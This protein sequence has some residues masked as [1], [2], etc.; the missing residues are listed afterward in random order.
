M[1]K[2]PWPRIA[3][4]VLLLATYV[5][6]TW[7]S[8]A[9]GSP[10][11]VVLH[12]VPPLVVAIAAETVTHLQNALTECVHHAHTT[13]T[14]QTQRAVTPAGADSPADQPANPTMGTPGERAAAPT[15]ERAG[16]PAGER[17]GGRSVNAGTRGAQRPTRSRGEPA[18]KPA[19]QARPGVHRRV[20][21]DHVAEAWAAWTPGVVVSPAW[22]RQVT[23][24]S[25]GLSPKVAAALNTQLSTTPTATVASEPEGRAA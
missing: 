12:S 23:D 15:G 17:P 25:R 6:N 24:C 11:G 2:P 18:R 13:A 3:K 1:H 7:T 20:L 19:A 8:W 21:A 16:T 14:H 22:V 4:W 9:A 5:M 10:S